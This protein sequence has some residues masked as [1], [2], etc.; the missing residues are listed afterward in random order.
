MLIL[1][2]LGGFCARR[3][4]TWTSR[5]RR[6][7]ASPTSP[8]PC[9]PSTRAPLARP[10]GRS[11]APRGGGVFRKALRSPCW[12]RLQAWQRHPGASQPFYPPTPTQ[13]QQ[14]EPATTRP[15]PDRRRAHLARRT[16]CTQ[17]QD[18][19]DGAAPRTPTRRARRTGGRAA[20]RRARVPTHPPAFFH[21]R[22][23]GVLALR[24]RT[25][26][27]PCRVESNTFYSIGYTK[28]LVVATISYSTR[29]W[30]NVS[31]IVLRDRYSTRRT[32]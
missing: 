21:G 4:P 15:A 8:R 29:H 10:P 31:R 28:T 14:H 2:L 16:A 26:R 3:S 22:G 18:P 25:S 9:S 19:A 12:A 1:A 13:L 32:G 27:S 7:S 11:R 5:W 24:C 17:T 30:Y 23:T 6:G 20:T